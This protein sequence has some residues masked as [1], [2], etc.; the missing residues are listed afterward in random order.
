MD[1]DEEQFADALHG[2]HRHN[3]PASALE[4]RNGG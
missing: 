3:Y 1:D 2:D 4:V